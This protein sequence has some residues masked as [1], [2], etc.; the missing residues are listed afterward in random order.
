MFVLDD[1]MFLAWFLDGH[2]AL[3]GRALQ[4]SDELRN[5]GRGNFISKNKALSR[6]IEFRE[7]L[8]RKLPDGGE[9]G[10]N[11]VETRTSQMR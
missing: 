3:M 5:V 6:G 11:G 1:E 8:Q 9:D 7:E 10:P 4:G 2:G